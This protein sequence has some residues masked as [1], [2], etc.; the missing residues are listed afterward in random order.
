MKLVI[1][2]AFILVFAAAIILQ[3]AHIS[4]AIKLT[5]LF[6]IINVI[7]V[8]SFAFLDNHFNKKD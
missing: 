2:F 7:L 6:F 1:H 8:V 3:I 5:P 4:G